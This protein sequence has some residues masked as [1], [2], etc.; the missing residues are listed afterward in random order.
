MLP[1]TSGTLQFAVDKMQLASSK[2]DTTKLPNQTM[3]VV[4]VYR[5]DTNSLKA[6]LRLKAVTPRPNSYTLL[7]FNGYVGSKL[8]NL[9][10]SRGTMLM[11][12]LK[13][14]RAYKL[15]KEEQMD[16]TL[17]DGFGR[18]NLGFDPHKGKM[19]CVM[20]TGIDAGLKG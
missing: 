20:A 15:T 19:Y 16:L 12:E 17:T 7:V 13:W 1:S 14:N 18:L 10:A 3:L 2:F 8:I 5:R 9:R 4:A 6:G 11:D